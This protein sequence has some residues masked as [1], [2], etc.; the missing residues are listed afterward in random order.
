MGNISS[1]INEWWERDV[2]QKLHEWAESGVLSG[3]IKST[4]FTLD[5]LLWAIRVGGF[6][7]VVVILYFGLTLIKT[8]EVK[9]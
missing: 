8:F 6:V 7:L 5:A 3:M 1:A 4:N 9:T 2:V